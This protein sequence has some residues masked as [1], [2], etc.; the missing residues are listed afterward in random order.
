MLGDIIG[1]ELDDKYRVVRRLGVGGFGDVYLAKDDLA[2]IRTAKATTNRWGKL[3]QCRLEATLSDFLI[4]FNPF[5]FEPRPLTFS[6]S[7]KPTI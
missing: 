7:T 3:N 2:G 5:S 4:R 1:E 6:S